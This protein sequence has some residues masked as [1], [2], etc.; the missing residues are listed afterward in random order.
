MSLIS[1]LR[2]PSWLNCLK[3]DV[4]GMMR[5]FAFQVPTKRISVSTKPVS[6]HFVANTWMSS[7]TPQIS[8][9][10][11]NANA[12]MN[13]Q[14]NKKIAFGHVRRK[15]KTNRAKMELYVPVKKTNG[16]TT[17][18]GVKRKRVYIPCPPGFEKQVGIKKSSN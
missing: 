2:Q 11:S 16:T 17:I 12:S 7:Y 9:I 4:P 3:L 14:P 1:S 6:V 10:E 8:Q 18:S 13:K 15:N 5:G